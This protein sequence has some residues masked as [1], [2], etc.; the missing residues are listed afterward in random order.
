LGSLPVWKLRHDGA[1]VVGGGACLFGGSC[2][3]TAATARHGFSGKVWLQKQGTA[4]QGSAA[5]ARHD[6]AR[7]GSSR[8]GTAASD[9]KGDGWLSGSSPKLS[10]IR[11]R[12][13][14]SPK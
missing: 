13:I 5:M 9:E 11:E 2:S 3:G 7:H 4:T 12:N 1:A 6:S 8:K 10:S 14:K